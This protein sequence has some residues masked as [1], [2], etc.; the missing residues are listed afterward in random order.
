MQRRTVHLDSHTA[1]RIARAAQTA[2]APRSEIGRRAIAV[3]VNLPAL[4]PET[5]GRR[6]TILYIYLP[7]PLDL[8]LLALANKHRI[9]IA[10][11]A[12][13]LIAAYVT[14]EDSR[15]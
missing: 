2:D 3:G 14:Q 11:A 12:R 4:P 7:A 13:R 8:Q 1:Q 15:E 6:T 9:S 10:S 5:E